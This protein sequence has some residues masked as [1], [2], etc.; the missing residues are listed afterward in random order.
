MALTEAHL[1]WIGARHHAV[2]VTIRKDGSPQTSNVSYALQDGVARVSVTADRAKTGNLRRDPRGVLHVLDESFWSYASVT[3]EASV[4]EVTTSPGDQA[5]QDL[6]SVYEQI[7][8]EPHPDPQE[9]YAAMVT[10]Q[11]LL[12][13]LTPVRAVANG[14]PD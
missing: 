7:T 4:G 10:E 12:L 14:L 3:V 11:R 2:L 9:F 6:L 13:S 1:S 5:G 8:G